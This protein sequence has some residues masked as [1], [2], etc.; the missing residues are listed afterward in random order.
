ML[1]DP[2]LV[3]GFEAYCRKPPQHI[4]LLRRLFLAAKVE[5]TLALSQFFPYY[6]RLWVE[7]GF[8]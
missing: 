6:S 4:L 1:D 3:L 2:Q 5:S 8:F 7:A